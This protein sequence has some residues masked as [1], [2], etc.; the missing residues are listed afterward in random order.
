[1]PWMSRRRVDAAAA[2]LA[3]WCDRAEQAEHERDTQTSGAVR[4]AVR[5]TE[6]HNEV[7]NLQSAMRVQVAA[8][9]AEVAR[10]QQIIDMLRKEN[11]SA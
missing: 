3:Q 8:H 9:N 6:K 4:L 1:M 11:A 7:E 5:L 2:R 10:L